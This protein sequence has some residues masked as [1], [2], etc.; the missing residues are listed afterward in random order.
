VRLFDWCVIGAVGLMLAC[1]P[2]GLGRE[3]NLVT[4]ENLRTIV[5]AAI[6]DQGSDSPALPGSPEA[7]MRE[8]ESPLTGASSALLH[9]TEK[10]GPPD[11]LEQGMG[12]CLAFGGIGGACASSNAT[13]PSPA[14]SDPFRACAVKALRGDYGELKDWQRTAYQHGLDQGVTVRGTAWVTHYW[15][16]EGRDGQVDCRGNRCT[17]DIVAANR[18]PYGTVVWLEAGPI[19]GLR[20]VKDRGAK[21][22]DRQAERYGAGL[23]IDRW[24]PRPKGNYMS[25]YAVISCR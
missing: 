9:A 13:T 24:N 21:R 19:C 20:I 6:A 17:S 23:W 8:G 16:A 1:R 10:S 18:L 7:P 14:E 4:R 12:T 11:D 15:P 5:S 3:P 22:N 25:D 2:D